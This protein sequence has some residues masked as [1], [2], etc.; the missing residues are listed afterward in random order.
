VLAAVGV[1]GFAASQYDQG[2]TIFL[3]NPK[4]AEDT[5]KLVTFADT[6]E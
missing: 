3:E 2:A 5:G 6:Q 4:S 1:G